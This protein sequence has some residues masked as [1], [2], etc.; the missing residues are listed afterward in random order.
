MREGQ[1]AL[2]LL[3]PPLVFPI[4]REHLWCTRDA[5]MLS[6]SKHSETRGR[7]R[8]FSLNIPFGFTGARRD[9]AAREGWRCESRC[10]KTAHLICLAK[11]SSS[12]FPP[13]P[14]SISPG[15]F[16]PPFLL[17]IATMLSGRGSERA[18]ERIHRL[19]PFRSGF[20]A[21]RRN[22]EREK[23]KD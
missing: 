4:N 3:S 6:A 20:S 12:F 18:N 14:F 23:R 19:L 1:R 7:V 22:D 2:Y 21:R 9:E 5:K 15:S 8:G 16:H 11:F 17:S 13:Q 10:R